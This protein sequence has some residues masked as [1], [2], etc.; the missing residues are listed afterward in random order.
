MYVQVYSAPILNYVYCLLEAG[1]KLPVYF[2][3]KCTGKK[4]LFEFIIPSLLI[5]NNNKAWMKISYQ[6]YDQWWR[7]FLI[8]GNIVIDHNQFTVW[9]RNNALIKSSI[10]CPECVSEMKE[11]SGKRLWRCSKRTA[12]PS[13]KVVKESQLKG[14]LFEG[15]QASPELIMELCHCNRLDAAGYIHLTVNHSENFIYPSTGAHT[16]QIESSWR[17][18]KKRI[19][20]GGVNLIKDVDGLHFWEY[21]WFKKYRETAFAN[22]VKHIADFY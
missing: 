15:A 6:A 10:L 9:L 16:Q 8:F 21:L 22:L 17:A 18:L 13:G 19:C 11:V 1:K 5:N 2:L 14:T 12:H 20:R 7:T 4:Y 3:K